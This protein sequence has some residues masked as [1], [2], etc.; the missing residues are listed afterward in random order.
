MYTKNWL[1]ILLNINVAISLMAGKHQAPD[2]ELFQLCVSCDPNNLPAIKTIIETPKY[3][4]DAEVNCSLC[5]QVTM[6]HATY[7]MFRMIESKDTRDAKRPGL[8]ATLELLLEHKANPHIMFND[9][10]ISDQIIP[11]GFYNTINSMYKHAQ[12]ASDTEVMQL[13][14]KYPP[15]EPPHGQY[16][17]IVQ[18]I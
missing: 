1:F 16:K 6:L 4:I 12:I 2:D 9:C 18:N 7:W 3:N 17:A 15:E 14:K 5:G 8:L 10:L 13:L 11:A